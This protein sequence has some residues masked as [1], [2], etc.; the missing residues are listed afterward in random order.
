MPRHMQISRY[1][2]VVAAR[3][4]VLVCGLL[5]LPTTAL[6]GK[7][8]SI[9]SEEMALIPRYCAYAQTFGSNYEHSPEGRQ[10]ASRFGGRSFHHIHHYCW[11]QIN[12][13]R[14][15]RSSTPR[16][17]RHYLLGTVIADYTYVVENA[18]R[19]FVLLPEIL[20]RKGEVELLRSLPSEANK[21]FARARALKP[22]Y[23]PA[24]SAWAEFLIRVGKN[25]EAKSIVKSGLEHSPDSRT[26][27][28]LYRLLGGNLSEVRARAEPR[29][30]ER[31][32]K[33]GGVP[34]AADN[35]APAKETAK[36][37]LGE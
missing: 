16:Q 29:V 8:K 14:A 36:A 2:R 3:R 35:K 28:D 33:E 17:E 9:T 19:D 22:D 27:R 24:Y 4:L 1:F 34:E 37:T 11:G 6:A 21:S 18:A 25:A 30:S 10:W 5:I 13:Q 12:L 31:T 26:L 7:P 23:W 32:A 20:T 15:L